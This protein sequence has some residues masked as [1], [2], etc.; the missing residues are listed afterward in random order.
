MFLVDIWSETTKEI[1]MRGSS[2]VMLDAQ[3]SG[4]V[5]YGFTVRRTMLGG[6]YRE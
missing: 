6:F 5:L 1:L 4:A 2:S 3:Q